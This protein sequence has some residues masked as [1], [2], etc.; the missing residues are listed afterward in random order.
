MLGVLMKT[1][2]ARTLAS[3][4]VFYPD[5]DRYSSCQHSDDCAVAALIRPYLLQ[6][7]RVLAER[8]L[9]TVW[10]VARLPRI[11]FPKLPGRDL[12]HVPHR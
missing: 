4:Q 1:P 9:E 7:A 6:Y 12:T 8:P 5:R 3:D 2:G 11:V 10:D